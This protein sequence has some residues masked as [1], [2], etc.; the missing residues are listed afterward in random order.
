MLHYS[1]INT[2]R[3]TLFWKGGKNNLHNNNTDISFPKVKDH[4]IGTTVSNFSNTFF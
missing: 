1:T 4:F 3:L 2:K